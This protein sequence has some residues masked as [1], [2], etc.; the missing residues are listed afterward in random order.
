MKKIYLSR[1]QS[2]F[3]KSIAE[4]SAPLEELIAKL[5][6]NHARLNN[7]LKTRNFRTALSRV[8]KLAHRKR[9]LELE[10]LANRAVQKLAE[11]LNGGKCTNV[12][13]RTCLDLVNRPRRSR[14]FTSSS[15]TSPIHP[16]VDLAEAQALLDEMRDPPDPPLA[17]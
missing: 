16:D 5:N 11:I 17:A 12:T 7:W 14:P 8:L 4:T 2:R 15:P 13:R 1:D 3:L 9:E 10:I 6:L